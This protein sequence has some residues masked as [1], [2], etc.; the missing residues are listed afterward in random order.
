MDKVQDKRTE[1]MLLTSGS[2]HD[3]LDVKEERSEPHLHQQLIAVV[4]ANAKGKVALQ[5]ALLWTL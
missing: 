4:Q 1:V 3:S 2:I 5:H